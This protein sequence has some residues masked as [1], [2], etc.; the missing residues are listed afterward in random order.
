MCITYAVA[1]NKKRKKGISIMRMLC[2]SLWLL[3]GIVVLWSMLEY[4]RLFMSC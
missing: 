3:A 2:L 1:T 4:L